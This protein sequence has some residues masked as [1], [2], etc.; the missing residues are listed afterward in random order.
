MRFC[1][2][3]LLHFPIRDLGSTPQETW[4]LSFYHVGVTF[5]VDINIFCHLHLSTFIQRLILGNVRDGECWIHYILKETIMRNKMLYLMCKEVSQ[6]Q[7]TVRKVSKTRH[8]GRN[9]A[10]QNHTMG[11]LAKLSELGR[12]PVPI[13]SQS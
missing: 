7:H 6:Q 13:N 3:W 2:S 9:L 5:L 11:M 1:S 4:Q 10:Q 12:H 8:G